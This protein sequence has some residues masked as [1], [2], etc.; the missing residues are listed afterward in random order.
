MI[1]ALGQDQEPDSHIYGDS[2][3]SKKFKNNTYGGYDYSVSGDFGFWK[4]ETVHL[5]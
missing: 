2:R 3:S 1:L 4:V 5:Y